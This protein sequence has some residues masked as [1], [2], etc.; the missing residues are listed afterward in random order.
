MS[1]GETHRSKQ[2]RP[3]FL[4]KIE[5]KVDNGGMSE[6]KPIAPNMLLL[7]TKKVLIDRIVFSTFVQFTIE[8]FLTLYSLYPQ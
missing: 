8:L 5:Q 1:E 6:G 3:P 7:V 2:F 4:R